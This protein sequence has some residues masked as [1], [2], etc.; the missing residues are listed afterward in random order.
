MTFSA[1]TARLPVSSRIPSVRFDPGSLNQHFDDVSCA[2]L[3]RGGDSGTTAI[4]FDRQVV[5][6]PL[7]IA[8]LANAVVF[9]HARFAFDFSAQL[10]QTMRRDLRAATPN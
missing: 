3:L 9:S 2:L 10:V 8:A 4:P 6:R 1:C 7:P 5:S